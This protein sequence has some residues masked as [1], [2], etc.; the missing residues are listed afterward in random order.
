[1]LVWKWLVLVVQ[2]QHYFFFLGGALTTPTELLFGTV[3]GTLGCTLSDATC[4]L[5]V[6]A[7]DSDAESLLP[8]IFN[9]V[10]KAD[11]IF[12]CPLFFFFL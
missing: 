5:C 4:V 6:Y 12:A 11:L 2:K 3:G 9:L 7:G 10:R 8:F 1:M